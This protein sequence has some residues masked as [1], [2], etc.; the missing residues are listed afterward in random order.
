MG[1]PAINAVIWEYIHA[2]QDRFWREAITSALLKA[3]HSQEAIDA[4][5]DF[6]PNDE[7][8]RAYIDMNRA[9]HTR[10]AIN[11]Q[12]RQA[13]HDPLVIDR[14]WL[15]PGQRVS[16]I[17]NFWLMACLTVMIIVLGLLGI[18]VAAFALTS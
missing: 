10:A 5:F 1:E 18:C 17:S 6:Q 3:G 7:P 8:V 4:A 12:L 15:A 14:A 11:A 9:T 2:H 13:G 16:R